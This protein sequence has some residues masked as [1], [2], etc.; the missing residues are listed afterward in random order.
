[1]LKKPIDYLVPVVALALAVF[2]LL[3]S[4]IAIPD[5]G[6]GIDGGLT[7]V[8]SVLPGSPVWRDEIRPGDSVI[9]LHDSLA[10]GG[11]EL[12]VHRGAIKYVTAASD[13]LLR[14]RETLPIAVGGAALVIAG[15]L[16]LLRATGIGFALLAAGVGLSATPLMLTGNPRDLVLGGAGT[17]LLATVTAA[18]LVR[19]R[20][21]GRLIP[22]VLVG[23]GVGLSLLWVTAIQ[24]LPNLFDPLDAGRLP[25]AGGFAI[26]GGWISINR[27]RLRRRLLGPG[28]PNAFDLLYLPGVIALLAGAMAFLRLA[29]EIAALFL[30]AAIV[31]YPTTRRAAA[32]T[33]EGL[34]VGN[35][36]RRAEIRATEDERGRLAR[37]IHDAPLQELA[38]VI[39][40]L[41]D[42]PDAASETTALRDIA[43]HLRDVA[44][45]LHPPVLEDLGLAPA[46]ADLGDILAAANPPWRILVEVD[47]LLDGGPRPEADAE[48]AAL[49][50]V[51]EATA[52]AIRHSGGRTLAIAGSV[53]SDA[54][55][56]TVADNGSGID[57]GVVA[58]ARRRGHFGLD[59]M[60]ERAEAAGG[61]LTIDSSTGGVRVRFTWERPS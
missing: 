44:A 41:E 14:L 23:I 26:F 49:R 5:S 43:S 42:K 32:A 18:I 9:S 29:P 40:R 34:I 50:V 46:V 53:S 37:D 59:S 7:E 61:E 6:V 55:D 33:F 17:F 12:W 4:V 27:G 28:G 1:M 21:D 8:L 15:I 22:A 48:M 31:A 60:R 16:L 3:T 35:V 11:W 47:D 2:G 58:A 10:P 30:V 45:S 54:I 51:Q 13:N 39:R 36:R 57:R 25:V 52:N 20:R 24:V 38:A 19:G 56:L